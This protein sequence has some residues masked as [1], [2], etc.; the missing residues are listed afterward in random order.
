MS[1]IMAGS[2][3][4]KPIPA[5][6]KSK[7]VESIDLLRGAIMI[8]MALDHVRD[9]FHKSAFLYSPT[10]L[11]QTSIPIFFTRFITHYCAPVFVFLAGISAYLSGTRKSKGELSL[12]LFKRGVWLL[13]AEVTITTLAW[14]F[15]PS[16]HFIFL[17]II[18]VFGISMIALSGLVFLDRRLILMIGILITAGHN[19]FDKVH[20]SGDGAFAFIWS[21]L[22]DA[23][24]FTYGYFT[25]RTHFP[26]L[27]WIGILA[28]G[29]YM[30][31]LYI[32]GY[33]AIKRKK[34]LIALGAGAIVLFILLRLIN[35]Y[36]DPAHWSIQK[37][38][39]FSFLS[40][41][42]VSKYPPSLLYM[43]ITLGP[44]LIFLGLTENLRNSFTEKIQVFGRVPMFYYLLHLYVI[45]ILAII[46]AVISGHK[47]TNM[48]LRNRVNA[49]PELTGYGFNLVTVY[50]IWIGV[51]IILYPFCKWFGRYK[52]LHQGQ[53]WWL[54]YL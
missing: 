5:T 16:Y 1:T 48:I 12:F 47:W 45:H 39:S 7:R 3:I 10:D 23:R 22:H 11:T 6:I 21:V 17:Q 19:L 24:Y 46:A 50:I 37:N 53:Y 2:A 43:L 18:F 27:P 8:V 42:N 49:T 44:A 54:S 14:T 51:I 28:I 13:I 29:Y 36:G 15:N 32:S 40:F 33:D 30:G 4:A 52:T 34:I 25:V 38:A 20:V 41:L 26:V 9:Y 31:G 35:S